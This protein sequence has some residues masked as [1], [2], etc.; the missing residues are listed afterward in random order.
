MDVKPGQTD[1]AL[2]DLVNVTSVVRGTGWL[3]QITAPRMAGAPGV[4]LYETTL[5]GSNEFARFFEQTV[6]PTASNSVVP[7]VTF[8]YFDTGSGEYRTLRRGP[9]PLTFHARKSETVEVYRPAATTSGPAAA[10]EPV[11][12]APLRKPADARIAPAITALVIFEIQP[13]ADIHVL[14]RRP[15]WLLVEAAGNRGWVPVDVLR[16]VAP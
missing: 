13:D 16:D 12:P 3:E 2:G 11:R 1:I 5:T 6:V 7:E 8:T 14:E 10:T 15:D 4:R 9:F